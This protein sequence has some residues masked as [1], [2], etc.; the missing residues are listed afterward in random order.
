MIISAAQQS[1]SV[2]HIH[3]SFSLRVFSY[4]DPYRILGRVLCAVQQPP[5]LLEMF[6]GP[7]FRTWVGLGQL[8]ARV[9]VEGR[10]DYSVPFPPVSQYFLMPNT[11]PRLVSA[12]P[13]LS[14]KLCGFVTCGRRERHRILG[15]G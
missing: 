14:L 12:K 10:E 6:L 2:I 7:P 1:E 4:I 11:Q 3:I 13:L 15:G 9:S 5:L 8:A